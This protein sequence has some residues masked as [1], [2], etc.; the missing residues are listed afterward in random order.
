MDL[1]MF[2]DRVVFRALPPE[3]Q[4]LEKIGSLYIPDEVR[5]REAETRRNYKG[6]V[7][8]VG[9]ECEKLAVGDI[10]AFDE[11]GCAPFNLEGEELLV[12]REK[13]LIGKYK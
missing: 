8:L 4:P 1:E 11:Y 7:V 5:N 3:D 9:D 10:V 13:D 2:G 6:E 12:I